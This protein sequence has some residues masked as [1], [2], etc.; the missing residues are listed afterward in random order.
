MKRAREEGSTG[1]WPINKRVC[2]DLH[3]ATMYNSYLLPVE[4]VIGNENRVYKLYGYYYNQCRNTLHLLLQDPVSLHKHWTIDGVPADKPEDF[5][6]YF[7]KCDS[8]GK[9]E[10]V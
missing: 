8:R 6:Q 2:N 5:N 9:T 4:F 3:S 10:D 1:E 7:V